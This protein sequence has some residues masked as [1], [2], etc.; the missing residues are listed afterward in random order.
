MYKRQVQDLHAQMELAGF[1]TVADAGKV[2][3]YMKNFGEFY[4][5]QIQHASAI[6]LSRTDT[7][8]GEKLDKAVA[9]I[10]E[11]NPAAPIVT[12]PWDQLSGAQ[13]LDAMEQKNS[14]QERCV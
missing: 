6:I 13:L 4:D 5:N 11:K 7:V 9:L 3:V 8:T 1:V 2:K 14:L 12:T 10:R